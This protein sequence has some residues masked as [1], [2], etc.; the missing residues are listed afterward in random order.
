M[1]AGRS[2]SRFGLGPSRVQEVLERLL[3]GLDEH[4]GLKLVRLWR[5]WPRVLGPDLAE[6]ARPLG[7]RGAT[8][9][10][11]S[12]DPVAVQE[13]A[14][15]APEILERVNDFLGEEVFDKV[16]FEMLDGRVPLDRQDAGTGE[17]PGLPLNKPKKLGMLGSRIPPDSPIGRLYRA[18][19]RMFEERNDISGPAGPARRTR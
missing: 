17:R 7:R 19:V 3:P 10:L 5:G 12:E 13:L 4:G 9:L 2:G 14:Y 11:A 18:Y 1:R 16:R 6:L 15:F 8:L